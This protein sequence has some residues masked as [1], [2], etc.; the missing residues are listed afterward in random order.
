VTSLLKI[1]I[2]KSNNSHAPHL[3]LK[4]MVVM[5]ID[6]DCFLH[7]RLLRNQIV[8]VSQNFQLNK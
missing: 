4:M 5:G 7:L 8:V 3:V 2:D 1:F 6:V